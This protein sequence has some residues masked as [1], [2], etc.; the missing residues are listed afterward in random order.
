MEKGSC[1][2]CFNTKDSSSIFPVPCDMIPVATG[3]SW[4]V[5]VFSGQIKDKGESRE[6]LCQQLGRAELTVT[7]GPA[8]SSD[9]MPQKSRLA[10]RSVHCLTISSCPSLSFSYLA[11]LLPLAPPEGLSSPFQNSSLQGHLQS[12]LRG[13]GFSVPRM[14][15]LGGSISLKP[16]LR[17]TK[18][19]KPLY[20]CS[21]LLP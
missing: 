3:A 9:S 17:E 12:E 11:S 20:S 19:N 6:E 13:M 4:D 18:K 21:I 15:E 10:W 8:H 2:A 14:C 16:V 1:K 7:Q 5:D